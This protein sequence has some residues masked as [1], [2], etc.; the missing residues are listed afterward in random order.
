[1]DF[2]DIPAAEDQVQETNDFVVEDSNQ[3]T[4]EFYQ[5]EVPSEQPVY[6]T[7]EPE[8][9]P[10]EYNSPPPVPEVDS[11]SYMPEVVEE[12]ALT[13]FNREWNIRLEAKRALEFEHEKA[14]RAQAQADLENWNQQR[15]IRLNAKAESNRAEQRIVVDGIASESENLK[16]WDRVSKLIDAGE[17]SKGILF[18]RRQCVFWTLLLVSFD[19]I[20][21]IKYAPRFFRNLKTISPCFFSG[22]AVDSNGADTGR[23]RKLFIQL[24]NEPLEQTRAAT[25]NG[26]T[27]SDL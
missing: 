22:E 23:M 5:E 2:E 11:F 6:V 20:V 24:K 15:E 7:D 8:F 4:E 17:I 10:V 1:M 9:P 18:D 25:L 27:G 14:A 21:Y 19:K 12:D 3:E 26:A 16:T 13:I